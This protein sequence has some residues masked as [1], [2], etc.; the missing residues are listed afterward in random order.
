MNQWGLFLTAR[1][2]DDNP[3]FW[4]ESQHGWHAVYSESPILLNK[5]THLAGIR[6]T[7]YMRIYI[8]GELS[9]LVEIPH[10]SQIIETQLDMFFGNSRGSV[11][12]W[13]SKSQIDDIRIYNRALSEAEVIALYEFEKAKE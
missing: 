2:H 11:Q 4:I 6:E 9:G 3:S 10:D 12:K 8:D 13:S 1:G 7:E 5:Q